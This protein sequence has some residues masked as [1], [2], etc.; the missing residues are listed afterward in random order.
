D[1]LVLAG[2]DP[3]G[4]QAPES[5]LTESLRKPLDA[6]LAVQHAEHALDERGGASLALRRVRP[7]RLS[8]ELVEQSHRES[9]LTPRSSLDRGAH[10]SK[11]PEIAAAD[12]GT[13]SRE[14]VAG[15]LARARSGR[16]PECHRVVVV[17]LADDLPA[18]DVVDGD[19]GEVHGPPVAEAHDR[20]P[21][22]ADPV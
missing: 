7:E 14:E 6:A 8:D 18:L 12:G 3:R 9:P 17:A 15:R 1:A 13:K 10:L 19:L 11:R 5:L 22:D 4:D 2:P 21:L 16:R 20:V